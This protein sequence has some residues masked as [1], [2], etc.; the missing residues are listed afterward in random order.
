MTVLRP[1]LLEETRDPAEIRRNLS[2]VLLCVL[3]SV[4][5][6]LV[7]FIIWQVMDRDAVDS[8][9][10]FVLENQ[11][12]QLEVT[13]TMDEAGLMADDSPLPAAT[14]ASA[15]SGGGEETA[16]TASAPENTPEE[17]P[18]AAVSPDDSGDML[19]PEDAALLEA[20]MKADLSADD[21]EQ[22]PLNPSPP[23]VAEPIAPTQKSYAT[24]V[25][26]AIGRKWMMPPE[27][28][29]N[30]R[31]GRLTV[32][33]TI[34]RNG[35]LLRFVIVESSGSASL[36][37]AGLEALRAAAPFP[38]FPG[39]LAKFSQLDITMNFDYK[40]RYINKTPRE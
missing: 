38:P 33:V 27:A 17:D 40:A 30:F 37:H 26:S 22:I 8:N 10:F 7:F 25:R 23:L 1:S 39:E 3:I 6:H 13:L 36:D 12:P 2:I 24:A 19:S 9:F 28:V 5:L 21:D 14:A 11:T 31:P 20:L 18:L 34:D 32:N 16:P 4:W 15:E 35:T 29:S